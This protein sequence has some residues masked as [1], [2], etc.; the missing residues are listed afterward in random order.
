MGNRTS[1]IKDVFNPF[2][3]LINSNEIVL[4]FVHNF[5]FQE[6]WIT[7]VLA[8][9][10]DYILLFFAVALT[11][12]LVCPSLHFSFADYMFVIGFLSFFYFVVTESLYGYSLGKRLFELKVMAVNGDE[13][14]FL[15]IVIRN[16]SKTFFVLLI[17]DVLSGYF[18]AKNL[19]Q[20]YGDAIAHTTVEKW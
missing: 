10:L 9:G 14:S 8:I 5:L 6:H 13:P 11:K 15:D 19:K 2:W 16:I 3:R 1:S 17:L 12:D 18:A 7:R 4:R 20:R